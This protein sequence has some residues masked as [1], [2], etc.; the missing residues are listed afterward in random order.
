V[1]HFL[2]HQP[3]AAPSPVASPAGPHRPPT[4]P[5]TRTGSTWRTVAR[6]SALECL[7][8]SVLLFGVTTIVRWVAGPSPVST[9]IPHIHAELTVIGACMGLLLAGLILSPA[10]KASGGHI[11]PAISIA[12]WRFGLI[13]GTAVTPYIAAQL[14]GSLLGTL[15]G[16]AAWG[17]VAGRPPVSDAALQ[18]GPGW[19]AGELFTA[20][21][22]STGV[23][24]LLLGLLLTAP[25][26]KRLVPWLVGLLTATAIALL[27]TTTGGSVNPARQFGPAI[28][29]DRLH[30]L[31]VYLLAP[32]AG[33]LLAATLRNALINQ[34]TG[35]TH[36]QPA[37]GPR[38]AHT[39]ATACPPRG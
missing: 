36:K 20:E 24:V 26:L 15:A 35:R 21:A 30:F 4:H 7:L 18:P 39:A 6:G 33:A 27:G 10:G 12:M 2:T 38:A 14:T 37:L 28:T 16:R 32:S 25:R 1:S 11:N 29:A 5:G 22:T 19:S 17:P 13:P 8:A 34:R 9:T 3:P 23:I 31:W